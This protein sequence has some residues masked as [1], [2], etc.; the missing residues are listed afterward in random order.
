MSKKPQRGCGYCSFREAPEG[1]PVC[2]RCELEALAY[3]GECQATG[4]YMARVVG[5]RLE[6]VGRRTT[7]EASDFVWPS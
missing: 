7:G 3:Y 6:A 4:A 5:G 1:S 2:A